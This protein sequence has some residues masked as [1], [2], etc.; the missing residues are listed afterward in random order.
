MVQQVMTFVKNDKTDPNLLQPQQIFLCALM[1][2]P[3]SVAVLSK[4][5]PDLLSVGPQPRGVIF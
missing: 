3:K 5:I 4:I 2:R 1:E